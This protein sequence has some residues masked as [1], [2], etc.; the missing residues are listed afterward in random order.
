M[1]EIDDLTSALKAYKI[2]KT[3]RGIK[4]SGPQQERHVF[5]TLDASHALKALSSFAP[6]GVPTI[7]PED[8]VILSLKGVR[9]K[10]EF[11]AHLMSEIGEL[12]SLFAVETVK[13]A[14]CNPTDIRSQPLPDVLFQSDNTEP[15][16]LPSWIEEDPEL[17]N[18]IAV[19]D[20]LFVLRLCGIEMQPG[21][22]AAVKGE[23]ESR[24][25]PK[26]GYQVIFGENEHLGWIVLNQR[27]EFLVSGFSGRKFSSHKTFL[28]ASM[29]VRTYVLSIMEA[30][31][32]QET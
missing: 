23:H 25:A 31:G 4:I 28:S 6:D 15:F 26:W 21:S 13:I 17:K 5:S 20:G 27:N 10:I 30:R 18:L 1:D 16:D 32:K 11:P 14:D 2:N 9:K 8:T 24:C 29:R 22:K 19:E 7:S 3:S 12:L